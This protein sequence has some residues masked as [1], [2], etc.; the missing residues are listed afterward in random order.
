MG[1]VRYRRN[2]WVL[3]FRDQQGGRRWE[4]T[5]Y[6]KPED[7]ERAV[8]LLRDRERAIDQGEYQAKREHKR[9]EDLVEAYRAA[10]INVNIR[11][12]T[13]KDYEGRI[14][15]HLLPYFRGVKIRAITY[16]GLNNS[17]PIC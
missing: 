9:F 11:E 8:K 17:G 10:H 4:T 2:R 1:C 6:T 16:H 5:R 13:K 15:N 12:T 7:Y 3:D 14:K